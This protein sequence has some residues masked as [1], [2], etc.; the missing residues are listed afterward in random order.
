MEQ[1]KDLTFSGEQL[2]EDTLTSILQ[3]ERERAVGLDNDDDLNAHREMA[4][5]Y[6]KGNVPDMPVASDEDGKPIDSNRSS[7]TT[8]DLADMVET[9]MPD[10]MEVFFGGEDAVSFRPS[11]EEDVQGAE[12]ETD[13]LRQIIFQR[14]DGFRHLYTWFKEAL[15]CRVGIAKWCWNEDEEYEEY[16]VE[17]NPVGLQ[18][19]QQQGIEITDAEQDE[20]TGMIKVSA[21][22]MIKPPTVEWMAVPSSD[23]ATAPD[24]VTLKESN[25]C[26]MR[27]RPQIQDLIADGYDAEIVRNLVDADDPDTEGVEFARNTSREDDDDS[28]AMGDLRQV[29][30]MEHYI[31]ADF[32]G[33]GKPCI[34]R[35]TTGNNE[36][37]I[38]DVEKRPCIEFAAVS[39]YPMPFRLHGQDLAD[40]VMPWQ[41]INTALLRNGLDNNNF[42]LNARL[43][44]AEDDCTDDTIDDVLNNEPGAHIRFKRQGAIAPIVSAPLAINP[45]ETI[46]QIKV[47]EEQSTGVVRAAQ[48][49]N[50]DSLHDTKGGMQIQ[51]NAAQKR[52]R[53]MAR[54]FAE[55]GVKDLFL[56]VHDMLRSN[57][58]AADTVR[59][60]GKFVE[61]DPQ[62]WG[63]RHDMNIEI[64]VGSGGRDADIAALGMMAER[65]S[66]I[67]QVQGGLNGPLV[68]AD[69]IY[70]LYKALG[71]RLG[72]K[73]VST[74]ISNPAEQPPQQQEGPSPEEQAAMAEMQMEQQK[75]QQQAQMDQQKLESQI[76]LEQMKAQS[77]AQLSRERADMEIGLAREK[78]AA[79]MQLA[80][81]KAQMEAQLARERNAIQAES[82]ARLSQDRPG[83]SLAQ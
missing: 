63:R 82:D 45:F 26:V 25:Y 11:N 35:I 57:A 38:L 73:Q 71:D 1:L 13:Y 46:E 31:R 32:G 12:Q 78:A 68:S 41:R 28:P 52:V 9:V 22:K 20:E 33:E 74:F 49:L 72:L 43:G 8:T 50:P 23:F 15:L 6:F 77:D 70:N 2:T 59:M 51:N 81:E 80:R 67:V 60:K 24:T 44:I 69:N 36:K 39:P 54:L 10:L 37:T 42:Q 65:T 75:I 47:F 14:N 64:G 18:E 17:V 79:E 7:A 62:Q 21:R 55:T 19:L 27:S 5:E 48:G 56:G 4:L 66:E 29:E 83:G 61:I 34:W 76:Q 30:V 3:Y 58:T 40:K 53:M 16:E